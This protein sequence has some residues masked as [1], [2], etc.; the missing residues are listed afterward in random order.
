MSIVS[1]TQTGTYQKLT[2]VIIINSNEYICK[3]PESSTFWTKQYRYSFMTG[4]VTG[5]IFC[6][7][8]GFCV[9]ISG[10]WYLLQSLKDFDMFTNYIKLFY[11]ID[12]KRF[13]KEIG[14]KWEEYEGKL[15]STLCEI[16]I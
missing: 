11:H 4:Q 6:D 1:S 3:Y 9:L 7:R 15:K 16:D 8:K 13:E 2:E 10:K 14:M 5:I 12:G